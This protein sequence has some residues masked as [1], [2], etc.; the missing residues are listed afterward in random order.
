MFHTV[1][2]KKILFLIWIFY[3][4]FIIQLKP[5][6]EKL[7][8]NREELSEFNILMVKN[9][10]CFLLLYLSG[11]YLKLKNYKMGYIDNNMI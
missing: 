1:C 11:C 8:L 2:K 9:K 6:P 3:I 10:K 7:K 4:V 5:G